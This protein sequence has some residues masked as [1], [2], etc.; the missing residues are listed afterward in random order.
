MGGDFPP[1]ASSW[2]FTGSPLLPD[3]WECPPCAPLASL[4]PSSVGKPIPGLRKAKA[5]KQQ[6]EKSH[7]APHPVPGLGWEIRE[8]K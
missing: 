6:G 7:F 4:D 5:P 8:I 3:G 1:C 2:D